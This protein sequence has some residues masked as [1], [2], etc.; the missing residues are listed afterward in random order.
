MNKAEMLLMTVYAVF[1][2]SADVLRAA[3]AKK[4]RYSRPYDNTGK[5]TQKS[6]PDA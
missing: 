4:L 3:N 1:A 6:R 2:L 5:G